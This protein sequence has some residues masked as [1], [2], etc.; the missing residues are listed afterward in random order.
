LEESQSQEV[1]DPSA[2]RFLFRR[3]RSAP[4]QSH[5]LSH[6]TVLL[7]CCIT[8]AAGP[9]ACGVHAV[10]AGRNGDRGGGRESIRA[11]AALLS[12]R[13]HCRGPPQLGLVLRVRGGGIDDGVDAE[14]AGFG[15]LDM[16]AADPNMAFEGDD[17]APWLKDAAES[18]EER[19][20]VAGMRQ[21]LVLGQDKWYDDTLAAVPRNKQGAYDMH[22]DEGDED[23]F[24][25]HQNLLDEEDN[26]EGYLGAVDEEGM[27]Q[28]CQTCCL[29]DLLTPQYSV[30]EFGQ[31][32]SKPHKYRL[33]G[34]G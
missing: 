16:D 13:A 24:K 28:V 25:A 14:G 17:H 27:T 34:W 10:A 30:P 26:P 2:K 15:N 31:K 29:P 5:P 20:L 22:A 4:R 11:A 8:S 19:E 12:A 7:A 1:V 33:C 18:D 32:A 21:K 9:S 23:I 6:I 3:K